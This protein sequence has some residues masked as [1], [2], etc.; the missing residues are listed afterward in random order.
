[1]IKVFNE[2]LI[3]AGLVEFY[4][5]FLITGLVIACSVALLFLFKFKQETIANE[6]EM[7]ILFLSALLLY[8]LFGFPVY[9][10]MNNL[11]T[12]I[13]FVTFSIIITVSVCLTS[14]FGLYHVFLIIVSTYILSLENV[15][16]NIYAFGLVTIITIPLT[17]L[18]KNNGV[19]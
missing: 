9:T 15:L 19:Y 6:S 8:M 17:L 11:Q 1:M 14:G 7:I 13:C 18:I 3:D 5:F 2:F 10:F 4:I 12:K 16:I